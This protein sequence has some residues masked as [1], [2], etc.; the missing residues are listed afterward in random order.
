MEQGIIQVAQGDL[1]QRVEVLEYS[2][3]AELCIHGNASFG[4]G[5]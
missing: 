5:C 2:D 3:V 4:N 1:T